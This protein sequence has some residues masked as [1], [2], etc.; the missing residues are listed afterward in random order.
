MELELIMINSPDLVLGN[1]QNES[2]SRSVT[3]SGNIDWQFLEGDINS[4]CTSASLFT[5]DNGSDY[6]QTLA[7]LH[8]LP[9]T[10]LRDCAETNYDH[11]DYCD[12]LQSGKTM[13]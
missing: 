13:Q 6:P 10:K 8:L 9:T 12:F 3:L 5:C 11:E 1:L 7:H 2:R 4:R